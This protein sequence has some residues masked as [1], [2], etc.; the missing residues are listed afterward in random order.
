M[1]ETIAKLRRIAD[2][3]EAL[4][5]DPAID[6]ASRADMIDM[7]ARWHMLAHE[8]AGLCQ[9]TEQLNRGRAGC[10]DC[11]ECCPRPAAPVRLHAIC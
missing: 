4:A 10:K 11:A 2:E 6:R 1:I 8:A 3:V 5:R 9:R 7:A